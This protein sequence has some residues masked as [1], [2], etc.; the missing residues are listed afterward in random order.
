MVNYDLSRRTSVPPAHSTAE[1]YV[2]SKPVQIKNETPETTRPREKGTSTSGSP[3]NIKFVL[4]MEQFGGEDS[5]SGED[6]SLSTDEIAS[7]AFETTNPEEFKKSLTKE[8]P[9]RVLAYALGL[10]SDPQKGWRYRDIK[11]LL[12]DNLPKDQHDFIKKNNKH[13]LLIQRLPNRLTMEQFCKRIALLVYHFVLRDGREPKFFRRDL[14][15]RDMLERV[16]KQT[17]PAFWETTCTKVAMIA[18]ALIAGGASIEE[19]ITA[20]DKKKDLNAFY[21]V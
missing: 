21:N 7:A 17:S 4:H 18:H 3:S 8:L 12:F 16:L 6:D 5:G 1:P 13:K 19:A 9:V 10:N 2:L 11:R 15:R 20:V 14:T